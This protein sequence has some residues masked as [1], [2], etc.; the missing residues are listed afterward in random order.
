M[1]DVPVIVKAGETVFNVHGR[2]QEHHRNGVLQFASKVNTA[3]DRNSTRHRN[4]PHATKVFPAAGDNQLLHEAHVA[5]MDNKSTRD[6]DSQK[7]LPEKRIQLN[8]GPAWLWNHKR[9]STIDKLLGYCTPHER[10]V[11]AFFRSFLPDDTNVGNAIVKELRKTKA[12]SYEEY[13]G[14]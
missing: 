3:N 5:R 13:F 2:I 12:I 4:K 6:I 7:G 1:Y 14:L 10:I 11:L 9:G 8:R